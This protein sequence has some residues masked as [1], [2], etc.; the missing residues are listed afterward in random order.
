M[1]LKTFG[2]G[3]MFAAAAIVGMTVA[4]A[5]AQ[6]ASLSPNQ[7]LNLFGDSRLEIGGGGTSA[8]LNFSD[9]TL[10]LPA[11]YNT[12][13][14]QALVAGSSDP[15][16]GIGSIAILRDLTL[17][18]SGTTFSLGAAVN[19]FI[20]LTNGIKF[21]LQSFTLTGTNATPGVLSNWTADYVGEFVAD[22]TLGGTG[23]FTSQGRVVS[24]NG[25]SFSS[26]VTAVP[27]PALLPGL[28]GMGVAAWRKRKGEAAEQVKA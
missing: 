3:T 7:T 27:T 18:G 22:N 20:T 1:T 19:S 11:L 23:L 4:S 24:E 6:A 2:F 26:S 28:I 9:S 14:G 10:P 8:V 21:N 5:P 13:T 25:S 12:P 15:V 16:F 17:T